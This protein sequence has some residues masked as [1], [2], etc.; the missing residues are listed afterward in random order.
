MTYVTCRLTAKNRISSGTLRSVIEYGLPFY[1]YLLVKNH[2][3][4]LFCIAVRHWHITCCLQE[5]ERF[6]NEQD[7][8]TDRTAL[9][10]D[11]SAYRK[12]LTR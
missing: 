9:L 1:L 4:C 5:L 10:K 11:V 3:M 2:F 6:A 7:Q 8:E 12:Q